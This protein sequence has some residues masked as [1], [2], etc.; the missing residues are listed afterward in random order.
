MCTYLR[1]PSRER[2]SLWNMFINCTSIPLIV[3]T[4]PGLVG[5][6]PTLLKQTIFMLNTSYSNENIFFL[7]K[8]SMSFNNTM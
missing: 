7:K 1:V 6:S 5:R 8:M 4:L 3:D 2:K